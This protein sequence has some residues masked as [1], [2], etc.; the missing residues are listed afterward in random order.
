MRPRLLFFLFALWLS[1]LTPVPGQSVSAT[2]APSDSIVFLSLGAAVNSPYAEYHPLLSPDGRALYFSRDKHPLNFGRANAADIWVAYYR[3]AEGRWSQAINLGRPVNDQARDRL[4]GINTAD[5]RIYLIREVAGGQ[6]PVYV[7][8][9]VGRSWSAP[10][11]LAIEDYRNLSAEVDA[12]VDGEEQVLLLAIDRGDGSGGRDLH[13]SLPRPD[14]TWAPP[15][16]LGATLNSAG[17]EGRML[18]AADGRTLYFASDG[19][20]GAGGYDLFM[21][22]RLDESW[23]AWSPP[24][25][26]G[27]AINTPADDSDFALT[28]DGSRLLLARSKG[29]K[30]MTD[31]YSVLLPPALR[32]LPTVLVRGRLSGASPDARLFWAPIG[33]GPANEVSLQTGDRFKLIL[34]ADL[35]AAALYATG[36][37][38]FG[39]TSCIPLAEPLPERPDRE[40]PGL[41]AIRSRY[42]DYDQRE[43]QIAV[44]RTQLENAR[45]QHLQVQSRLQ[46]Y[47]QLGPSQLNLDPQYLDDPSFQ[48][49]ETQYRQLVGEADPAPPEAGAYP[50]FCYSTWNRMTEVLTPAVKW[51]LD[52]TLAAEALLAQAQARRP[53][54]TIVYFM[55]QRLVNLSRRQPAASLPAMVEAIV[56]E[57]PAAATVAP[58]LCRML[59]PLLRQQLRAALEPHAQRAREDALRFYQKGIQIA[60]LEQELWAKVEEQIALENSAGSLARRSVETPSPPEAGEAVF[61]ELNATPTLVPLEA[62]RN[63]P[64][65]A[66]FFEADRAVLLP[67]S[68]HELQRLTLV[69]L[70]NPDLSIEIDVHTHSRLTHFSALEL[71]QARADAI[72]DRLITFGIAPARLSAAGRGKV[73]TLKEDT[74]KE[75]RLENQRVEVRF[76]RK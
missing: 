58:E 6:L 75:G 53:D 52:S 51:R 68:N 36:A 54:A 45:E 69:L 5:N 57:T 59:E 40:S 71:T 65:N 10:Q 29:G 23:M 67:A 62:D 35:P 76:I 16:N 56:R 22:R 47:D 43:A 55:E 38:R 46:A 30:T 34:P 25:P 70:E 31:L 9:R 3:P 32:P 50:P 8:E 60:N 24:L 19:H 7:I 20:A 72:A 61:R 39:I 28:P 41:A 73:F 12:F 66:V 37:G 17:N 64:L 26:L 11:P 1:S 4:A 33:G 21:S 18:L 44:L 48:A 49:L 2:G 42:P 74:G 63:I 27:E 15:L 13:V 14:G